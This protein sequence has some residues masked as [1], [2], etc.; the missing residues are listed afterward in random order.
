VQDVYSRL[1]EVPCQP[2]QTQRVLGSCTGPT[3]DAGHTLPFQELSEPRRHRLKRAK[4][5]P[6]PLSIVERTELR[7]EPARVIRFREMEHGRA[8]VRR[9]HFSRYQAIEAAERD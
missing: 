5:E 6:V 2:Y 3:T 4:Q 1:P 9:N 8:N 7:E